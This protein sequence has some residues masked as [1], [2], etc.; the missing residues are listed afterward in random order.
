MK[1]STIITVTELLTKRAHEVEDK[2]NEA[3]KV[4]RDEESAT[5]RSY[6]LSGAGERVIREAAHQLESYKVFHD[7]DEEL[8]RLVSALRDFSEHD[9]H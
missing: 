1:A 7:L 9:F 4:Y 2:R 3:L 6:E 8:E 5:Y